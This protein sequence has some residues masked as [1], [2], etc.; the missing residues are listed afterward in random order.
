MLA[1]HP[2][3]K[4]KTNGPWVAFIWDHDDEEWSEVGRRKTKAGAQ[5]LAAS[6][7]TR[8]FY[9][10]IVSEPSSWETEALEVHGVA[11]IERMG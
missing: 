10:W 5:R 9:G 7:S 11:R 4:T 6:K 2:M 1:L 8:R 3:S